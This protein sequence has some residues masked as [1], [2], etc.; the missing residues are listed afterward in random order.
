MAKNEAIKE[1]KSIEDEDLTIK[2]LVE[3]KAIA[4]KRGIKGYSSMKKEELLTALK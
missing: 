4:K 2:T 3:L 1:E